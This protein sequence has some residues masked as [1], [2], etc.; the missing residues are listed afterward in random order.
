MATTVHDAV[1]IKMWEGRDY[2]LHMFQIDLLHLAVN[3]MLLFMWVIKDPRIIYCLMNIEYC[4]SVSLALQSDFYSAC[5][6][7]WATLTYTHTI[8]T[9]CG[10]RGLGERIRESVGETVRYIF[11]AVINEQTKKNCITLRNAFVTSITWKTKAKLPFQ[12]VVI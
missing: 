3:L 12:W 8:K 11:I 10:N 4:F 6:C 9:R 2:R 5:V 7:I 1:N